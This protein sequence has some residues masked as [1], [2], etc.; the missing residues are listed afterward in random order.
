MTW[1]IPWKLIYKKATIFFTF[2]Q[3]FKFFQ[4]KQSIQPAVNEFINQFIDRNFQ[5]FFKEY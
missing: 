4:K 2:K 3:E 1:V 5:T